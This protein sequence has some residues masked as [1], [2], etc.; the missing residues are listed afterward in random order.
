MIACHVC[1]GVG[2][3]SF[4]A[5]GGGGGGC[6]AGGGGGGGSSNKSKEV[7]NFGSKIICGQISLGLL[8]G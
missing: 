3:S 1:G 6:G 2:S 5:C 8:Q 7:T 4:C